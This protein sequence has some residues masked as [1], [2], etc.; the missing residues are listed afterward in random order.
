MINEPI[1]DWKKWKDKCVICHSKI[2]VNIEQHVKLIDMKGKKE[3]SHCIYHLNCWH[4][5]FSV[6]QESMNKMADE[7][8]NKIA[9][10]AGGKKV[11]EF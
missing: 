1:T 10:M 11:V 4:N 7:W 2:D 8:L 6:T 3:I 5:R 9:N